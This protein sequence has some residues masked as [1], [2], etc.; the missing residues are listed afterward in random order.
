[1]RGSI[2]VFFLFLLC[3][4]IQAGDSTEIRYAAELLRIPAGSDIAAMGDAG[5]SLLRRASSA[6]WN[7]SAPAFLKKYEVSVE[8]ADLY[9]GLSQQGC[10]AVGIPVDGDL[11]ASLL[12]VPFFSGDIV[13]YDS[14][15]GTYL[16]RL[17]NPEMRAVGAGTGVFQNYQNALFLTLAKLFPFILPRAPGVSFPLPLD[18]AVGGSIKGYWQS[19]NPAGKIRMGM[20]LNLDA[21]IEGIIGVDYDFKKKE[22]SRKVALGA[23]WRNILPSRIVWINSPRD[24]QEPFEFE[25]FYGISYTDISGNLYADWAVTFALEKAHGLIYHEGIEAELWDI[26]AIRAGLSGETPSVGAGVHYRN[27]FMDYAFRFDDL[28]WSFLRITM[29][30]RF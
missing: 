20:G 14:L 9:E 18:I 28:A 27:W 10:F 1:M 21:G 11:G 7:P 15:E 26:V 25:Q 13:M 5:V 24:Y 8:A 17:T 19:M 16:E 12:Y 23:S 22:V 30:M 2:S 6:F 29:G 3:K 4:F